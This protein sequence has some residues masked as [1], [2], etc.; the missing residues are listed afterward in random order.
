M[1]PVLPPGLSA[2]DFA[3]SLD[4]LRRIVGAGAVFT[5]EQLAAYADPYSIVSDEEAHA[6]SAAVAPQSVEQVQDIVRIANQYGV[7]LWPVSCGK[8]HGYGGPAPRMAGTVVLD[9]KDRKSTRL[10]SSHLV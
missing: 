9:L 8:N 6:A 3:E 10:N 2:G 4:A 7:P 1:K 5:G